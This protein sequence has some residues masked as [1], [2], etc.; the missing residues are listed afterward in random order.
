MITRHKQYGKPVKMNKYS[1]FDILNLENLENEIYPLTSG[2]K[3]VCLRIAFK[4]KSI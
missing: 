2:F 3:D 4:T 1:L